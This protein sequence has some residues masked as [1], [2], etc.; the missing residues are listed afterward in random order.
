MWKDKPDNL[1]C[2]FVQGGYILKNNSRKLDLYFTPIIIND[3]IKLKISVT[4][5]KHIWK[6]LTSDKTPK[7]ILKIKKKK[8][9]QEIFKGYD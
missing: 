8:L 4:L 2:G 5:K 9:R 7:L 3:V 1:L 6:Y